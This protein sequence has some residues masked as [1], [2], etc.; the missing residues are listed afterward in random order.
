MSDDFGAD[1]K[2]EYYNN[3]TIRATIDAENH[4][5]EYKYD[6]NNRRTEV[7]LS[8]NGVK[9]TEKVVYD[10]VGNILSTT[11]GEN[12]TTKYEYDD[13]NRR[14]K[15]IDPLNHTTLTT[16]DKVGNS[17]QTTD[18]K[19]RIAK[20]AYDV[21]NRQTSVT[22][23]FGTIDATTTAYGYDAVGNIT[24]EIDGRNHTTTYSPDGLN[25]QIKI[26]DT[27]NDITT[28]TYYETPGEVAA[29]IQSELPNA[30]ID[31]NSVGKIVK[32]T[33]ANGYSTLSIYD[34]IGRLTD[35]Y[36]GIK[37]RTSHITYYA[38]D[39]IKTS[40]DTFGKITTYVYNDALRQTIVTDPLGL[41]TTRTYNKVGNLLAE[42]DSRNRTTQ[43][44]YDELNRQK[45][46]TD[47]E[48][49]ITTYTYYNDGKTKSITDS[50]NNTTSYTYDAANRLT[51]EQSVL[52]TRTY[53]YDEVDNQTSTVDR[54][55][56]TINYDYDNLNRVK[57]ELWVTLPNTKLFTYTYDQNSNLTSADDGNIKYNYSYDNTDLLSQVDRLT[58]GSPTVSFKYDYDAVGNLTK[59]DELI[60]TT[61]TAS[62]VYQ[63]ND[64]R[65][66]NTQ[67]TQTGVGLVSKLV[68]FDYDA[69]GLN[70]QIQ[71]YA[72]GQ[73]AV[74]TTDSYDQYGR[75]VGIKQE[76]P[77]SVIAN[78]S[79]G[80][81]NLS[82]LT[83]ETIDGVS[84]QI[85]YDKIDQV[86]SVTGSNSEAYTYDKNGNRT[87]G[88][89]VTGVG[90][91]LLSDGTYNYE[92][93]D[94]GNRTKR[95]NIAT[96][97]VDEYVW[98]YRNRLTAVTSK[99]GTGVVTQTV[100][101]EYDVDDQRVSK[102]VGG[103]RE[104]YYLDRN[105]IAFVTDGSG[106]ETFHYLYGLNIDS[107]MAQDS[108]TGMVWS[109][110]DRLGSINLLADAGGVVVDK[111]TYDSFGR[112]LSET[113]PSVKFRYGYTGR[114]Q[115]GET[116]LDYYR[117]RYYDAGNGR[118][119][120]V[121]PMGFGAG[122]TNL[123]RYVGNSS[124][125][126][127]D[128][129][130]EF[131]FPS[132]NDIQR[133]AS[134]FYNGVTTTAQNSLEYYAGLAVRGQNEGGFVGGVK[135]VV[136][137]GGGLLSSLA[138]K[139]N[140]GKTALTLAAPVILP[141]AAEWAATTAVG[142]GILA[143][144]GVV[145]ATRIWLGMEGVKHG[146]QEVGQAWYGVGEDGRQ[147]STPE[148]WL[149]GFNGLLTLGT[150]AFDLSG[151]IRNILP[152]KG[153]GIAQISEY[154]GQMSVIPR[155]K[156]NNKLTKYGTSGDGFQNGDTGP[157]GQ[158]SPGLNRATGNGNN[159]ADGM[160]QSHHPVQTKPATE[161]AARHRITEYK[162]T[163]APTVLLSTAP[164][165]P[166]ALI[167]QMQ[168]TAGHGSGQT[169]RQSFDRGYRELIDSGVDPKI[170]NKVMK[171]NYKYYTNLVEEEI[172][173]GRSISSLKDNFN[174][175]R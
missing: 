7:T 85:A 134:D 92:Y 164:G 28:T 143:I 162:P 109:L 117:A 59:S 139:D 103:V 86:K 41:T 70:T 9:F 82:R 21:L 140:I 54:N 133:G 83:S 157:H 53:G 122:D 160:I 1:T 113:N 88:G 148:R 77:Q 94:E 121:D 24:S 110:G 65:N 159:T 99:D 146:S 135:Q 170:A 40:T 60:G 129:T 158:L 55:G 101:Y 96:S 98:D 66:L 107:V 145:P 87:L 108:P 19:G 116:G 166:H 4:R 132:W 138:T 34:R 22:Q 61:V 29:A 154:D 6:E 50:V 163:K 13:S 91:K 173:A 10:E 105:Q 23:A 52:G 76:N 75:L 136:G 84:R 31:L 131:K 120:S 172:A 73:L 17:T 171:E 115:D 78:S 161:W 44:E 149:T 93:D 100:G 26:T 32:T 3:G 58:S 56:R 47:A 79:Y 156:S 147:L 62:T 42:T 126:Y 11:D 18:A 102:T 45:T 144:P 174:S 130:G 49:G 8:V 5:T 114:E 69:A 57:S 63:Y 16:Y 48:G 175:L 97:V 71:R 46:I 142:R 141:A 39:R 89:Y 128:P 67:I 37:H 150:S 123:Y 151:S 165:Q 81:D 25:R 95:T 43:Y 111:R 112:V 137:T 14:I 104:N 72:N 12:R 36:D 27:Y 118:F 30:N 2:T 106:T 127:T 167:N 35:T 74:T 38:D 90:N 20:T 68:K 124:T 119:I 15:T 169:L 51:K 64:P 33:D 155:D 125:L 80:F 168:T 152:T 153:S